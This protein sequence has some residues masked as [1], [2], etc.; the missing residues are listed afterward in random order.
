MNFSL[1]SNNFQIFN[2]TLNNCPFVNTFPLIQYAI[3]HI[4]GTKF[5]GENY[6]HYGI[7]TRIRRIPI[8][9]YPH[10]HTLQRILKKEGML[11]VSK[12]V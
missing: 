11:V 5:L 9:V 7:L 2:L 6:D 8:G 1:L 3:K 4:D 10:L 12:S